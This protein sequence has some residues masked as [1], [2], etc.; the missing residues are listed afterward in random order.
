LIIGKIEIMHYVISG[1]TSHTGNC[2]IKRLVEKVGAENITCLVRSSSDTRLLQELE[3]RLQVGDVTEPASL[4]EVLRPDVA[5]IDMTHPKHYHQSLQ[6]VVD[7]GVERAYFVTTTGIFSR[8]NYCSDIYK[9]NEARIRDSGVV[10][11]ILR[12]T[13]IY[14]SRRDKNMC[15][16]IQFINRF[17][18]FPLFGGGHSLMQPVFVDDLAIGIV[19]AIGETKTEYQ[20]YNLAG[21]QAIKYRAIVEIIARE[22]QR[23]I[24][25]LNISTTGAAA[26]ARV[27]GRISGF[28]VT[29]EQVLRLQEDKAFDIAKAERELNY[30]PRSFTTGIRAEIADLREAGVLS[31]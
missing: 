22:L 21:P 16:L 27:A 3:L 8:Y 24:V 28:P 2:V 13:M 18:V 14:G 20:E 30:V 29:H 31:V 4:V 1:A 5:Y 9:V 7:A 23:K 10:Y 19:A 17:P 12:P 11:T 6:A 25:K 26:V 15:R